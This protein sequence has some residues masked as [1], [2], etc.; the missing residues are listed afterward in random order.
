MVIS[1][2]IRH[3][4]VGRHVRLTQD[5]PQSAY[6]QLPSVQRHDT[7]ALAANLFLEHYMATA[8]PRLHE[9]QTLKSAYRFL[10]RGSA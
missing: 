2:E 8:L 7:N 3:E 4:L 1:L 9:S 10:S 6:R 5:A